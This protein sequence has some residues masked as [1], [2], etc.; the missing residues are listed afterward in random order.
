MVQAPG[1]FTFA[2]Q[3][4][5]SDWSRSVAVIVSLSSL[6]SKRK[7]DRMGMVVLRSTTDCAAVSSRSNSAR[8]T[9]ISRLP[10]GAA[11]TSGVRVALDTVGSPWRYTLP[12]GDTPGGL[13][14]LKRF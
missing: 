11:A 13:L 1:F 12:V 4:V 5:F 6:A 3:L 10:V 7:F 9:V 8:E 14:E 2:A